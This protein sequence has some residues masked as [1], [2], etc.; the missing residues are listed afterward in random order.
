MIY[1]NEKIRTWKKEIEETEHHMQQV[2]AIMKVDELLNAN[3]GMEI[4][5]VRHRER[6]ERMNEMLEMGKARIKLL[7]GLINYERGEC[8]NGN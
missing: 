5:R 6:M 1:E 7:K 4:E 2:E 8:H 3:N